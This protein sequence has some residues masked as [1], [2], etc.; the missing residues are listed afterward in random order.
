MPRP[1]TLKLL[2]LDGTPT[3]TWIAELDNCWD[4]KDLRVPRKQFAA[5]AKSRSE[6]KHTGVY[7][8][9]G[10]ADVA[11]ERNRVYVGEAEELGKRIL[12]PRTPEIEW[13]DALVFTRK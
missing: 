12:Q 3:G 9:V 2:L 4:G 8:F 10:R 7:L 5:A 1:Q 13:T 6:L 11:G